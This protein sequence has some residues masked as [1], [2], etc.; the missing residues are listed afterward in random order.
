MGSHP[1]RQFFVGRG[2]IVVRAAVNH[3][4]GPADRGLPDLDPS[5]GFD[6]FEDRDRD[7]RDD[8]SPMR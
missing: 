7:G 4:Q 1:G 8:D 3:A 6:I 5:D 2:Q